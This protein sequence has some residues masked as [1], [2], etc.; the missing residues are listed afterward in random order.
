M[1]KIIISGTSNGFSPLYATDGKLDDAATQHIL[2]RR[3]FLT[4]ENRLNKEGYSF[5][6][7]SSYGILFHKLILL[8]DGSGREGFMMASLFLPEGEMLDGKDIKDALDAVIREYKLHTQ[9]G[10]ANV[11]LDWSFVKKKADELNENKVKQMLW[12]KRPVGGDASRTA[13]IKGADNRVE[14]YFQYPN[15]LNSGCAGFGLVFLTESLLNPAWT[16]ETIEQGYTI[17]TTDDVSIDDPEYDIVYENEQPGAELSGRRRTIKKKELLSS[18]GDLKLGTYSKP[19]YHDAEV[20]LKESEKQSKDGVTITVTLPTLRQK[21]VEVRL[22]IKDGKTDTTITESMC[23]TEWTKHSS[24]VT[25][26][27]HRE[28]DKFVFTGTDCDENWMFTVK[29]EDYEDYTDEIDIKKSATKTVRLTPK[30]KWAIYITGKETPYWSG[31]KE[32]LD[33]GIGEAKKYLIKNGM[34]VTSDAV[35]WDMENQKVIVVGRKP[36][37]KP[38]T[39]GPHPSGSNTAF[40]DNEIINEND[41]EQPK[42]KVIYYLKLNEASRGYKLFKDDGLQIQIQ[43]FDFLK[44]DKLNHRLVYENTEKPKS[45]IIR[46]KLGKYQYTI[47]NPIWNEDGVRKVKISNV[48]RK[49]LKKYKYSYFAIALVAAVVIALG[50]II[51]FGNGGNN[52][53]ILALSDRMIKST[54]NM[55][56]SETRYCGDETYNFA[57]SIMNCYLK[58]SD[59]QKKRLDTVYSKF[60]NAYSEQT[61]RQH[62]ADSCY[63]KGLE[64]ITEAR[65]NGTYV[66][67][68]EWDSLINNPTITNEQKDTLSDELT[69]QVSDLNTKRAEK[70]EYDAYQKCI[71]PNTKAPICEAFLKKYPNSIYRGE[72]EKKKNELKDLAKQESEKNEKELYEKCKSAKATAKD[73]DNYLKKFPNHKNAAEVKK[74]KEKLKTTTSTTTTSKKNKIVIDSPQKAFDNLTWDKVKDNGKNFYDNCEPSEKYKE[75]VAK[76]INI[77]NKKGQKFY[78]DA[79]NSANKTTSGKFSTLKKNLGLN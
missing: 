8:S 24:R 1:I 7:I 23:T 25:A 56:A 29:S 63:K 72:V 60:E 6:P 44:Y 27:I 13:L 49:L 48:E 15:P 69:K 22:E 19:G 16:S 53:E 5:Q 34:E 30:L 32:N 78:S 14:E 66:D 52:E 76:I 12:K 11:N 42:T 62:L 20:V 21:R 9:G 43:G 77:A 74:I 75:L 47:L 67:T 46:H 36:S 79:Y 2:D 70:E 58:L 28:G 40:G 65:N 33:F 41:S 35:E 73:C 3:K 71:G 4:L 54:E 55:N 39:E 64:L 37:L 17:L 50:A 61:K 59:R 26:V 38:K 51:L 45:G 10:K 31:Y 18:S 68:T 57:D